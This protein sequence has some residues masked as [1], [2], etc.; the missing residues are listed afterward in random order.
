MFDEELD[1][2]DGEDDGV[3]AAIDTGQWCLV[4]LPWPDAYIGFFGRCASDCLACFLV[5]VQR[6]A[7]LHSLLPTVRIGYQV[8]L[9]MSIGSRLVNLTQEKNTIR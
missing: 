6:P 7:I 8:C 5:F 1:W 4:C 3:H 9:F 2:R